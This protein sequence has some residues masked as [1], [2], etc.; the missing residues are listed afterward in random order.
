MENNKENALLPLKTEQE[1][2]YYRF[3][4]THPFSEPQESLFFGRLTEVEEVYASIKANNVFLIHGISGIGKSSLINA[5]LIPKLRDNG[6]SPVAV[7][8]GEKKI[9]TR[10]KGGKD[11]NTRQ[12]DRLIFEIKNQ[13]C[14]YTNDPGIPHNLWFCVK[15]FNY[16]RSVPVIIFDQFEEFFYASQR[17]VEEAIKPI[18][19]LVK[20]GLPAEVEKGS[21]EA[22]FQKFMPGQ[23]REFQY[24]QPK[25]KLVFSI[26]SD[27]LEKLEVFSASIPSLMNDRYQLKGL[28]S[29]YAEQAMVL[30]AMLSSYSIEFKS[31]PF[32]FEPS[33]ITTILKIINNNKGVAETTQLQMICKE[34]EEIVITK[35]K[36]HADFVVTEKELGGEDG[37]K[38]LIDNYYKNQLKKISETD[39]IGDQEFEL[40]RILLDTK[41]LVHRKRI[42]L[43]V[44]NLRQHFKEHGIKPDKIEKIVNL[45]LDLRLIQSQ[46]YDGNIFY[47]IAHDS[48][49]DSILKEKE[50]KESEKRRLAEEEQAKKLAEDNKRKKQEIASQRKKLQE[51]LF[52]RHE[53]ESQRK[54]AEDE[55]H[56]AQ[57]MKEEADR[58]RVQARKGSVIAATLGVALL[59]IGAWSLNHS[60]NTLALARASAVEARNYKVEYWVFKAKDELYNRNAYLAYNLLWVADSAANADTEELLNRNFNPQVLK[61]STDIR[62]DSAGSVFIT[63]TKDTALY[64]WKVRNDVLQPPIVI[65]KVKDYVISDL[66]NRIAV[67]RDSIQIFD[68]HSL[69][70]HIQPKPFATLQTGPHNPRFIFRNSAK[71]S[72]TGNK[73]LYFDAQSRIK[74]F[75][76]E[77]DEVVPITSNAVA[78]C[79]RRQNN[80]IRR[81]KPKLKYDSFYRDIRNLAFSKDGSKLIYI[82]NE[83]FPKKTDIYLIGLD[84]KPRGNEIK[85]VRLITSF[86]VS[87]QYNPY[88]IYEKNDLIFKLNI[89]SESKKPQKALFYTKKPMAPDSTA[90]RI[91]DIFISYPYIAHRAGLYKDTV[92]VIDILAGKTLLTSRVIHRDLVTYPIMANSNKGFLFADT[93]F[94]MRYWNPV[95]GIAQEI[96]PSTPINK[97]YGFF[98]T[99]RLSYYYMNDT[100]FV[101]D[102][103]TGRPVYTIPN[104]KNIKESWGTTGNYIKVLSSDGAESFYQLV[105]VRKKIQKHDL[106]EM[107]PYLNMTEQRKYHLRK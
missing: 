80:N 102:L 77:D 83:Y 53:A 20:I 104:L 13:L 85:N 86:N 1:N 8:F 75:K 87:D 15:L 46:N 28:Q 94:K 59:F 96:S 21:F 7:R 52:L 58:L 5:G 55:K 18:A 3:P 73:F 101:K 66:F 48:L 70:P 16:Y 63:T 88:L 39:Y 23:N 92:V 71:F 10:N 47:E 89:D 62:H 100:L 9:F 41:L 40:V 78:D 32:Q 81:K 35:G 60:N 42:L 27:R 57:K 30:P 26:R 6:F 51:E 29:I 103:G 45:L 31:A 64:I 106:R 74:I 61:S 33:L 4:G 37:I 93:S 2:A 105:Y 76:L 14:A 98:A 49:V 34:I 107:I 19:E 68:L 36:T 38:K 90:I 67:L 25:V 84:G 44:T 17:D 22:D 72:Y 24:S 82:Y 12:L 50:A 11:R 54:V 69:S 79:E 91:S 99:G 95:S 97:N 43:Y 56:R 65:D